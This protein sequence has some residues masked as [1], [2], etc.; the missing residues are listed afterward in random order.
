MAMKTWQDISVILHTYDTSFQAV[1]LNP[2]L[3]LFSSTALV[4][5]NESINAGYCG[6]E[7]HTQAPTT[8][9]QQEP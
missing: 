2:I 5:F 6:S 1:G 3:I 8:D 9:L 7:T 4:G